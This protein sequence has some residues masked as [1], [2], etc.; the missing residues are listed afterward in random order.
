MN[1]LYVH[2]FGSRYDP[3]K[4]KIQALQT[5]GDV[6]GV[7]VDYCEGFEASYEK[8]LEAPSGCDLI[9]DTSMGGFMASHVGAESGILFV[10]MNPAI[11]PRN[12]LTKY[13]GDFI[14]YAGNDRFLSEK[15]VANYPDIQTVGGCGLILLESGD[16]VIDP[17]ATFEMLDGIYDVKTYEGGSHRFDNLPM[18][19]LEIK[20]FVAKFGSMDAK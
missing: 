11:K 18:A 3:L 16:E 17:I 12:T 8:V 20:A 7:D 5:L 4:S 1:I 15:V 6:V 9:V 13:V 10:A 2:G 19:L 14:D